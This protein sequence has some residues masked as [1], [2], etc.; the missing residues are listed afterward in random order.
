MNDYY[1]SKAMNTQNEKTEEVNELKMTSCH[2][3]S[4]VSTHLPA[5]SAGRC[6]HETKAPTDNPSRHI[7]KTLTSRLRAL[8]AA[9]LLLLCGTAW[10]QTTEPAVH[11]AE[12]K[13]I[14]AKAVKAEEEHTVKKSATN[15]P[16]SKL[17]KTN[18]AKETQH[19]TESWKNNTGIFSRYHAKKWSSGGLYAGLTPEQELTQYRTEHSKTFAN[20]DGT[21]SYMYIGDL[22]YKDAQGKWQDIE[23]NIEN[24]SDGQYRYASTKNKFQTF[25]S[26]SPSEG[27]KMKYLGQSLVFAKDYRFEFLDAQGQAIKG[28]DRTTQN[29]RQSDF[30]TLS[31]RNFYNNIDYSIIQLGRGVET[32]F[33]V[34][35]LNAVA[36]GSKIVRIS[37]TVEL[38]QDAYIVADGK[39]QGKTFCASEFEILIPGHDS[40]ITFQPVVVYD[41]HVDMDYIMKRAE[42]RHVGEK[43]DKDGKPIE[44][45][46][47]KYS[48]K[49]LYNVSQSGN[50]LTVSFD[51][52]AEWLLASERTFPLFIDPTVTVLTGTTNRTDSYTFYNTYY[53][54][55]RWDVQISNTELIAAGINN[56]ATISA[57]GLLCSATPGRTVADARID[58]NNAAW[59]NGAWVTNGWT[60]CYYAASLA[61][62]T[63]STTTWNTYTFQTNF[64]YSNANSNLLVRL[65]KDGT[66]YTNGGGNYCVSSTTGTTAR[67]GYQ[68]NSGG[69]PFNSISNSNNAVRPAMQ[70]TYTNANSS[71]SHTEQTVGTHTT[72]IYQRSPVAPDYNYSYTQSIY[73]PEDV[74]GSSTGA[75]L[76]GIAFY[77]YGRSSY[78]TGGDVVRNVT[79]YLSETSNGQLT[80]WETTSLTQVYSGNVA[81]IKGGWTWITFQTPFDYSGNNNLVVT[82]ND[83]S[84]HNYWDGSGEYCY[85]YTDD[86]NPDDGTTRTRVYSNDN[87]SVTSPNSPPGTSSS[88]YWLPYTKFCI[89]PCEKVEVGDLSA[90][91]THANLPSHSYYNYSLTQQ[92]YTPC[93]IGIS[94]TLSSISFYNGGSAKTRTLDIYLVNTTKTTFANTS[95]WITVTA[96]DRVFSGSVTMAA[97]DWTTINFNT[98]FAYNGTS[99]LAVIV[100]DNTGG[101]NSGMACRVYPA[102]GNQTLY[103][104]SD[105]TNYNPS[106]PS[107]TGTL[108]TVKN[109][110]KFKSCDKVDLPGYTITATANPAAGGTATVVNDYGCRYTVTATANECYKFIN[111][112]EG[113]T[114][115]STSASYSFTA[116]GNRTLVANFE[117]KS[118][119]ITTDPASLDCLEPGTEV[120]L[121]AS[122]EG[123]DYLFSTGTDASR[124]YNVTSTTN[125][126]TS[127]G[128]S[129][130]SSLQNIGFTF[131]FGGTG[132]TQFSVNSDGNLRLGPT[133]TGT[134]NY[135]TPFS[136]TAANVNNP[137][138][139]GFG[140]DGYFDITN[141]GNYVH[142]QVFGTAP[143]RVL[144]VEF[145]ESP[146]N[147]TYRP[148]PW[149]WQVQLF[150][151]GIVQIVYYSTAPASYGV[152]NQIGMCA[153]ASDGYTVNTTTHEATHFTNGTS[154]T[155]AAASS[156]PGVNRWYRFTPATF[157]WSYTGTAGTA[158]NNTYTVSP[159]QNSTYTATVTVGS[160]NYSGSIDIDI[161]DYTIVATANP[162]TG[163][164]VTKT[165]NS[166]C[167]YTVTASAND[168]YRFVNWTEDGSEVSTSA[169]YS[170]DVSSD[171]TLVA[172][173]EEYNVDISTVPSPATCLASG[174]E[175]VLTASTDIL[176]NGLA[177]YAFTTGTD[178]SRW[179]NVTSTTNIMDGATSTGDYAYSTIKD[180]GFTFPFGGTGYTQFSVN[181]DGNLRL[182]PTVTGTNNYSTPFSSTAANVNN[183]K[184][185]GFGF[186]GYFDITNYGN[187]VHMQ[188]FGTAPN[189]VLVVEFNESPY[190]ST[191]RPYPWKWQVQLF[192]NGIV[193]IVY[194]ST[195]PTSY[196]VANQVGLCVNASDG[197]TVSTTTHEATH[198]TNGTSTTNTGANSWPGV[199][200]WYRFTPPCPYTWTYT[201]TAGTAD[202]DTYTASPTQNSS[203]TV[204]VSGVGCT[205]KSATVNVSLQFNA[206]I[207]FGD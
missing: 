65:S 70:L 18:T 40:W 181:S 151:N 43:T 120:V 185:N 89:A 54:D 45:P 169:S 31:Y 144:V 15:R 199:N 138:I 147:S 115:V 204:S 10:G 85:F 97:G 179:Y 50:I 132:Y 113:G 82:V 48:Y 111:W 127:S 191:Y 167:N 102:D 90:T 155:N 57:C 96:S 32:G 168:C 17:V 86:N 4:Q 74:C 38:P 165:Q 52:P 129:Y 6:P 19:S 1:N 126:I 192:E 135:S 14:P 201:G 60:N 106:S 55:S 193:Q 58:L 25:Y 98:P 81:F 136:S 39:K 194:Y 187:Y 154:T 72:G 198:F 134:N 205:G 150:E 121:T 130:A 37:Q 122:A 8:A 163:G 152:A 119:N 84:G 186:D 143:N 91:T 104:C 77:Y 108:T 176:M 182:G 188:V 174:T 189:R 116:N 94:G 29:A 99:N 20:G 103:I 79:I 41:A 124:W 2:E 56:G 190:N 140:F 47:A 162:A 64:T 27:I 49:A 51:L 75:K 71:C 59:T 203:Y 92:I 166:G 62:P 137:K 200:R 12:K 35:N 206:T 28:N 184:I 196:G 133:V 161:S 118:V 24:A 73:T 172:N 63:V 112:T 21:N 7:S 170:F 101:Y 197:W 16:Q 156:W 164:T 107:Y 123:G 95:D 178:A 78:G 67:G 146:Y 23:V 180:I 195:A 34:K 83:L 3:K 69:Y 145:N 93:E 207:E 9:A 160:C 149:K 171:R 100:D 202:C 87:T 131:P 175:V 66:G 76:Y 153:N 36:D 42:I 22:H 142:M 159:T 11:R 105:G 33:S 173:F 128:D 61:T 148:Y 183:P 158:S 114:E 5:R 53:H 139:N 30:R 88:C 141:Y 80:D 68:D 157:A 44:D 110:L 117:I 125:L 26:D 13:A 109:Q 177:E 46:M